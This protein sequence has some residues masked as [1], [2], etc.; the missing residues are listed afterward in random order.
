MAKRELGA[1]LASVFDHFYIINLPS[2][3]DRR[4]EIEVQLCRIG[5]SLDDPRVTL[6][7]AIRPDDAGD[8]PTIGTRGCFM[9]HLGVLSEAVAAGHRSIAII[10]DDLDWSSAFLGTPP[11]QV[12]AWA[13]ADWSYMHAGLEETPPEAV[14]L[15]P[16]DPEAGLRLTHFIGLR[17]QII[18]EMRDYLTAMA[19]RPEGSPEGGPMHVDGGYFW[20]RRAHP[21][22]L[23]VVAQPRMA[24]QRSSRTDIHDLRLK[25]R[26][27]GV[28]LV[29]KHLRRLR[30]R[31]AAR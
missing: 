13:D 27:P 9:S 6:F 28:R 5:L 2:R 30:N 1:A 10:E 29:V 19:A 20:Y 22:R 21:Q 17:G 8:W 12:A 11:A 4:A 31:I 14:A 18:A 7:P 16:L 24:L 15:R 26:I 25:D 3:T 23:S